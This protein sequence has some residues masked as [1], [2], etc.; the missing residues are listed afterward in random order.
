LSHLPFREPKALVQ[1]WETHTELHN[2]QV[3]V[4]DYLDWKRSVTSVDF[5]A[6]TFQAPTARMMNYGDPVLDPVLNLDHS[7]STLLAHF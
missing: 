3:S 1:V 7:N 6:Y 5:E 2:L 4:P